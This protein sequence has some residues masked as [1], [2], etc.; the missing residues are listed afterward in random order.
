MRSALVA[1]SLSRDSSSRPAVDL[2]RRRT[3]ARRGCRAGRRRGSCWRRSTGRRRTPRWPA[4]AT[5]R[6][7]RRS[8]D[9]AGA[10]SPDSLQC[11]FGPRPA[12]ASM[13]AFQSGSLLVG[14]STAASRCARRPPRGRR[15]RP[16]P[17]AAACELVGTGQQLEHQVAVLRARGA[18][19]RRAAGPSNRPIGR[20]PRKPA[21]RHLPVDQRDGLGDRVGRRR[22]RR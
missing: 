11:T 6:T 22:C 8:I 21:G 2:V 17:C 4:R 10:D 14:S 18:R 19:R 15:A 9:P 16:G 13:P 3:T 7:R 5:A 20:T 12:S 1:K